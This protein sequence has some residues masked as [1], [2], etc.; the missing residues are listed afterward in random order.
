MLTYLLKYV[1]PFLR[2]VARDLEKDKKWTEADKVL[3]LDP[4]PDE[5]ERY[6]LLLELLTASL[7]Y[8]TGFDSLLIRFTDSKHCPAFILCGTLPYAAQRPSRH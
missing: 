1:K 5:W 8:L 3:R 2:A 7:P 6:D 4:T